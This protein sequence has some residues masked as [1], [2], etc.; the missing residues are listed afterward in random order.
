MSDCCSAVT[1]GRRSTVTVGYSSTGVTGGTTGAVPISTGEGVVGD[2]VNICLPK[3]SPPLFRY[4]HIAM[5]PRIRINTSGSPPVHLR[6]Y[7][8]LPLNSITSISG[9]IKPPPEYP[10]ESMILTSRAINIPFRDQT[11]CPEY[12]MKPAPAEY[13]SSNSSN[14]HRSD[15]F[16][17]AG[18]AS[19]S[20]C[21]YS[22][23]PP[24]GNHSRYC[25]RRLLAAGRLFN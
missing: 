16:Q 3:N 13:D 23:R 1:A 6:L 21:G 2:G 20:D 7:G 9:F 11:A 10:G 17:R 15:P 24:A 14:K 22:K 18:A 5:S 12:S 25:S 8:P 4:T 19:S